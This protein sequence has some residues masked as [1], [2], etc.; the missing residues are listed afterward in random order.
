[1]Q[2][3]TKFPFYRSRQSQPVSDCELKSLILTFRY[4]NFTSGNISGLKDWKG[5]AEYRKLQNKSWSRPFFCLFRNF[6]SL[7]VA[8]LP[9]SSG[10]TGHRI[11]FFRCCFCWCVF[12]IYPFLAVVSFIY[13]FFVFYCCIHEAFDVEVQVLGSRLESW[14]SW[15][16]DGGPEEGPL[17]FCSIKRWP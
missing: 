7:T 12:Y 15:S 11:L 2:S 5:V 13:F 4:L 6:E 16:F 17:G 10:G 3:K 9:R 14:W 8:K 1:M